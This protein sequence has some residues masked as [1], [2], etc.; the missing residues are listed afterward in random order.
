MGR[1]LTYSTIF[2]VLLF[3]AVIWSSH[4]SFKMMRNKMPEMMP[5]GVTFNNNL[6]KPSNTAMKKGDDKKDLPPP[7]VKTEPK[8]EEMKMPSQKVPPK[9]QNKK[10]HLEKDAKSLMDQLRKEMGK[11]MDKPPKEDNFPTNKKGEVGAH[12]T[13]GSSNIRATPGQMALN[14]A[15]RKY[16]ELPQASQ[17]RK[18][19]PDANGVIFLTL[20]RNGQLLALQKLELVRSSG[21]AVLDDACE[22]AIRKA[23][24]SE[25]FSEDV[26]IEL[27]GKSSRLDCQF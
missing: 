24:A 27:S 25:T 2:H 11:V 9:K 5:V 6:Y 16:F 8:A 15:M 19:H 13:G 23:L 18:L 4:L 20:V 10:E 12:G 14:T 22:R 17:M 3:S 21:F 1:A 7:I 26:L